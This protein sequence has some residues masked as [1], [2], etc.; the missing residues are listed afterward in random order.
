MF[1]SPAIP[2][3]RSHSSPS[4][5][6]TF[7]PPPAGPVAQY[8]LISHPATEPFLFF[9]FFFISYK[10]RFRGVLLQPPRGAFQIK[11]AR[12]K[13]GCL[14]RLDGLKETLRELS[15]VWQRREFRT[16][17]MIFSFLYF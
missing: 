10:K 14:Q 11:G 12:R 6:N 4:S 9:F 2:F 7:N 15:E 13:L 5:P 3:L 17:N 8:V 1:S 16:K